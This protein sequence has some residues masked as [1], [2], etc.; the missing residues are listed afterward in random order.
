MNER[1]TPRP[2]PELERTGPCL[3]LCP[4]PPSLSLFPSPPPHQLGPRS[5]QNQKIHAFPLHTSFSPFFPLFFTCTLVTVLCG[6]HCHY[7]RSFNALSFSLFLTFISLRAPFMFV[8]P[9]VCFLVRVWVYV[10]VFFFLTPTLHLPQSLV[11]KHTHTPS[12]FMYIFLAAC[13]TCAS[14][15]CSGSFSTHPHP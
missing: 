1:I 12:F 8:T 11:H 2:T 10:C 3:S 9:A 6:P 5:L 13:Q 4:Y 7:S 14:L 15:L